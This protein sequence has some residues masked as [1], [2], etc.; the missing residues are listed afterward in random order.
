MSSGQTHAGSD[1]KTTQR[2]VAHEA[3]ATDANNGS[4]TQ[5][6]T[7]EETKPKGGGNTSENGGNTTHAA[8]TFADQQPNRPPEYAQLVTEKRGKNEHE[9]AISAEHDARKAAVL[10]A[11]EEA[12]RTN[13]P[14]SARAQAEQGIVVINAV[15]S[16]G[17][18]AEMNIPL[19]ARARIE[20]QGTSAKTGV[21][22][23]AGGERDTHVAPVF[24]SA[25]QRIGELRKRADMERKTAVME[26]ESKE[27]QRRIAQV[28]CVCVCLSVYIYIYMYIIY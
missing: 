22:S 8:N 23:A 28:L 3:T 24:E 2:D 16:A 9:V 15:Q 27:M 4:S 7:A 20:P 21:G 11:F 1:G 17:Y 26:A 5:R 14:V 18:A 19:S 6:T 25:Q 13:M 12:Q 10:A